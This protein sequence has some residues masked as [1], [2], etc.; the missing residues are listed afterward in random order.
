MA[1]AS[2]RFAPLSMWVALNG[3]SRFATIRGPLSLPLL[4]L[5]TV[6]LAMFNTF[7]LR[8]TTFAND[9]SSR[10]G[11]SD[12]LCASGYDLFEVQSLY[13]KCTKLG[14]LLKNK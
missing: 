10:L 9:V 13:V 3:L 12:F 8:L 11:S 5:I 6:K 4:R 1:A 7:A 14:P 2:L